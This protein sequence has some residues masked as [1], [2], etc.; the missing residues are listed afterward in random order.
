MRAAAPTPLELV[1]LVEED[2]PLLELLE[3]PPWALAP[4]VEEG[5]AVFVSTRSSPV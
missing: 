5:T 2:A 3:T 1:L 4:G